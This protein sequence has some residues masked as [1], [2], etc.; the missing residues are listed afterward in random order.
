MAK[1]QHDRQTLALPL[2]RLGRP[3][4]HEHTMSPA[5]RVREHRRRMKARGYARREV[6]VPES[7]SR[8][9]AQ[10]VLNDALGLDPD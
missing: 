4:K 7:V 10:R 9:E 6:W 5:E 8:A 1:D 2:A 3:P